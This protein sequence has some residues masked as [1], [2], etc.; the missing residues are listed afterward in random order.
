MGYT[1]TP[2]DTKPRNDNRDRRP[3]NQGNNLK[4][5]I[6]GLRRRM[7]QLEAKLQD[8]NWLEGLLCD[9]KLVDGSVIPGMKI[10]KTGKFNLIIS[11]PNGKNQSILPKQSVLQ[12]VNIKV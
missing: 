5:M 7:S 6:D 9:I 4:D 2:T 1:K 3:Q 11:E 10:V 12:Y 8:D